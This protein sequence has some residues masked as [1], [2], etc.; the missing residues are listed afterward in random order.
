MHQHPSHMFKRGSAFVLLCILLASLC[1]CSSFKDND[2]RVWEQKT[3]LVT[4]DTAAL[5]GRYSNAEKEPVTNWLLWKLLFSTP[6]NVS[7]PTDIVDV[8]VIAPDRIRF[9]LLRSGKAIATE[10]LTFTSQTTHIRVGQTG[11]AGYPPLFWGMASSEA[12][13]GLTP[14]NDAGIIYTSGSIAFVLCMPIGGTGMI[15]D[16]IYPRVP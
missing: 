15:I 14:G 6:V 5:N 7:R 10:V 8:R 4:L 2:I 9:S 16:A 3:Q 12:G 13:F 1:S 11:A